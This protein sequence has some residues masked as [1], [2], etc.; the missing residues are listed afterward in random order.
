MDDV[1]GEAL[2][3]IVS[4]LNPKFVSSIVQPEAC[5][6]CSSSYA[7]TAPHFRRIMSVDLNR[8]MGA[9]RALPQAFCTDTVA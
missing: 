8:A 7:K 3:A 5:R 9:C 2:I 1:A 6:M 4:A